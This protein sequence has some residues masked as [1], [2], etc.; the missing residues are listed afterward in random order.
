VEREL[1]TFQMV[2]F[3]KG[4]GTMEKFKVLESVNGQMEKLMKVIGLIIRKMGWVF[5]NGL[6]GDNIEVI[7]EMIKGMVKGLMFGQMGENILV[8]GKMINGMEKDNTLLVKDKVKKEFGKR[9]K[10]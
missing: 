4:N 3:T 8:N 2:K 10:E 1:T 9:I 6:T 5:T 7:I